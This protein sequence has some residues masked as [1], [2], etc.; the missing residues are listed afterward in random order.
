[1]NKTLILLFMLV[2]TLGWL[3]N[4]VYSELSADAR[5]K[6]FP[7]NVFSNSDATAQSPSGHVAENQIHVYDSMVVLDV[8]NASWASFTPTHSMDPVLS[9]SSH[10]IEVK[11]NSESDIKVGDVVSYKS[12]YADGIII[13]R[14]VQIGYDES[15]WF[16]IVKGDNNPSV[17]P[18]KIRFG[19][20]NGILV[21]IIY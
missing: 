10:G 13:H 8:K 2:F 21:G 14:V 7:F 20:I 5:Q 16:A 11:P 9:D 17:D 18:G 19:Q 1:M 12:D 15:G 6:P 4:G 3:T